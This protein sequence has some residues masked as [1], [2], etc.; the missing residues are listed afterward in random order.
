MNLDDRSYR[1]L[2]SRPRATM[3][4]SRL[5]DRLQPARTIGATVMPSIRRKIGAA[6]CGPRMA[7]AGDENQYR[8]EPGKSLC[9]GRKDRGD[10]EQDDGLAR[11]T[12][13]VRHLVPGSINT[14]L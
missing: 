3:P 8:T 9:R 6:S 13:Q 7:L 2:Q 1:C 10:R 5:S 4:T 14:V 11:D 12:E